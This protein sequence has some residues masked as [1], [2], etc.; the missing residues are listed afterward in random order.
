MGLFFAQPLFG[1]SYILQGQS[2]GDTNW[3][4]GNVLNWQELDYVP[5]RLYILPGS[6]GSNQVITI[7]FEHTN[8]R[9]Q[10]I[11]NLFSF[12]SSQNVVFGSAPVL[13]API[14]VDV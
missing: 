11:Q 14:G 1:A 2:N 10:G 6:Q 8:G 3:V 5:C 13:S 12:T 9:F 7:H 4:A